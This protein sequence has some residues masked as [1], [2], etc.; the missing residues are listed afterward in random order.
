MPIGIGEGDGQF[1]EGGDAAARHRQTIFPQM[2]IH[3]KKIG[4]TVLDDQDIQGIVHAWA[5]PNRGLLALGQYS[6][7]CRVFSVNSV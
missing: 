4:L 3:Q 2:A 5:C 6:P 7:N 1:P